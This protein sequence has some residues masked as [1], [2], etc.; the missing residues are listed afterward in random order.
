MQ[1][2]NVLSEGCAIS[3]TQQMNA[4]I[5]DLRDFYASRLGQA[6]ARAIGMALAPLWQSISQE[7]LLGL[8]YTLPYLD[9]LS[10]DADRTLAFM[11]AA[12]GAIRWP[13]AGSSTSA[14]VDESCLPLGDA[15]VDRVLMVHALEFAENP[16]QLLCEVWRTLAPGG[17]L[18]IVIPN[19]SGVWARF[20]RTP[21]G[22]GRPWSRGQAQRLLHGAMFSPSGVNQALFFPPFRRAGFVNLANPLERAG[23]RAWPLFAGVFIIE[24][25]KLV[26]R[27]IPVTRNE[28][29][30]L[31]LVKPV[32]VPQGA[33]ARQDGAPKSAAGLSRA[34]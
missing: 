19:R 9:R 16:S 29:A 24:A 28:R 27:G 11:P 20:D 13:S 7:R 18:V 10:A 32:L 30:R 22:S 25:T 26:Y 31:R 33:S 15:S 14:M 34:S 17:R 6:T 3:I 2:A 23:R 12:Q 1:E 4:D 5:V 21:F 8:G